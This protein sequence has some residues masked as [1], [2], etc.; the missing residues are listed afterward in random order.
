M[1][2]SLPK[3]RAK[4]SPLWGQKKWLLAKDGSPAAVAQTYSAI[5]DK[6]LVHALFEQTPSHMVIT[7]GD[8]TQFSKLCPRQCPRDSVIVELIL[9]NE[10]Q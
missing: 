9:E 1:V 4:G 5:Y 6:Q 7:A 10:N 8:Y 3:I 2:G